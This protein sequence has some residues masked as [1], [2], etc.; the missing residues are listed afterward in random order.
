ME[1]VKKK[2][3][4]SLPEVKEILQKEDPEKLDQI[5]RWTYDYGSKFAKTD[6]SS[7]KN[8]KQ[9]LIKDCN[10]TEEEAVEL[11]NISPTTLPELRSFTFG[12]KKLILAE[13]LEKILNIIKEIS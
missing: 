12:W 11:I 10:L 7:A 9:K 13:N 5:Q 8:A 4:I 6:A 2:Q 3:A 1:E